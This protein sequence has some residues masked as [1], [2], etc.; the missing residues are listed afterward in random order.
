MTDRSQTV[1]TE[2]KTRECHCA[3]AVGAKFQC[4]L[5]RATLFCRSLGLDYFS[6][7]QEHTLIQ[8]V[9]RNFTIVGAN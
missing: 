6:D 9:R 1:L 8:G 2:K 3:K 4:N 7:G 5:K